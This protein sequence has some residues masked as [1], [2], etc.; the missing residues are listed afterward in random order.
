MRQVRPILLVINIKKSRLLVRKAGNLF[1][2]LQSLF[3][4][5]C[6]FTEFGNERE[7]NS[8]EYISYD[9]EENIT[10]NSPRNFSKVI[11]I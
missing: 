1:A 11:E 4:V 5:F 3:G 10:D 8:T 2:Y 6:A 7:N 9:R